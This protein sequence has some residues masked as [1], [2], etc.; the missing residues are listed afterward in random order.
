MRGAPPE[1]TDAIRTRP[2]RVHLKDHPPPGSPTNS[3]VYGG[4]ANSPPRRADSATQKRNLHGGVGSGTARR[5]A[6]ST[7]ELARFHSNGGRRFPLFVADPR[8]VR[9]SE[10]SSRGCAAAESSRRGR[11]RESFRHVTIVSHNRPD[12]RGRKLLRALQVA[13]VLDANPCTF[14]TEMDYRTATDPGTGPVTRATLP[15]NRDIAVLS[16]RSF[17]WL[18]PQPSGSDLAGVQ[19]AG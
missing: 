15:A 11:L 7:S 18:R 4:S 8:T 3:G 5:T 19:D 6:I 16:S 17:H 13:S 1:S 10:K 2:R 9:S 12:V 14:G